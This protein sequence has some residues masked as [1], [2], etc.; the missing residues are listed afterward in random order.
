MIQNPI[1][2][3][4]GEEQIITEKEK[5]LHLTCNEGTTDYSYTEITFLPDGQRLREEGSEAW[6]EALSTRLVGE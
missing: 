2:L 4:K 5:W 6:E 1:A 3:G